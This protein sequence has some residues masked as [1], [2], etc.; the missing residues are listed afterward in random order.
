MLQIS[1]YPLYIAHKEALIS[2]RSVIPREIS[3]MIG[4]KFSTSPRDVHYFP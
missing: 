4:A 2:L 1:L 3:W